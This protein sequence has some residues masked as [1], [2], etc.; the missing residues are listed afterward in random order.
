MSGARK[1]IL[2][3]RIVGAH[4]IR[5]DVQVVT[6]T[7]EPE[8]IADYGPLT[9]VSGARSFEIRVVRVTP[10]GLIARIAGTGDRTAAEKLKGTELYVSRDRLPEP[11]DGEYYHED[12]FGLR[13]QDKDGNK[14]GVVVAV[15]NFGAGD[16]LE[17]RIEGRRNTELIPFQNAFVPHVDIGQGHVTVVM[18]EAGPDDEPEPSAPSHG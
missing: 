11:E 3:G 1:R 14:I 15:V 12:L 10:K 17:I 8:A 7:G 9:D 2:L 16:L 6:F 4:G 13:A 18:P 5:G